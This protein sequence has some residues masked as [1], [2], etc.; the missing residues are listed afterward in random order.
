LN[1]AGWQVYSIK[2][3]GLFSKMYEVEGVWGV[4][5]RPTKTKG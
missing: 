5:G 3:H 2:R 1:T 4:H